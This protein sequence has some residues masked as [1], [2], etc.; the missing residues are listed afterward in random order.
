ME[1]RYL[2]LGFTADYYVRGP[3]YTIFGPARG[4]YIGVWDGA[5]VTLGDTYRRGKLRATDESA[6]RLGSGTFSW[7]EIER[8][9]LDTTAIS[10][11]QAAYD[12]A[13]ST[14]NTAK[15]NYDSAESALATAF[16]AWKTSPPYQGQL[17]AIGDV[18]GKR[19]S[20]CKLRFGELADLPFGAF[21]GIGTFFT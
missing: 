8:W 16:D 4:T 18:C 3:K 6:N 7:F 11:A 12:S 14:Y 20:S 2:R 5:T 21:P 17:D 1:T 15:S 10:D 13:L 9:A 19:L